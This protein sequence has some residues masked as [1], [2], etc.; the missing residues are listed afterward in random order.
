MS[1][2]TEARDEA[3]EQPPPTTEAPSEKTEK[4]EQAQ[5]A[6]SRSWSSPDTEKEEDSG[7]R[8][9]GS[10]PFLILVALGVAILIKTFVVQ[11]F[12][13]PSESMVPTLEVGDRV[14]VNKILF[15][16]GDIHRFDVVVFENPNS[17]ELPDRS[18]IGGFLHWLGEGIGLSQPENEDF[19]KRVI[20]LP[21]ETVEIRRHTVYVDGRPLDEPYLT[22]AARQANG[23]WG[24]KTVPEGTLFVMGDNRGN[25]ADS[26]FGL[27]F[28]PIDKVV[29]KAFIVIWPP[30]NAGGLS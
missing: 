18:V 12:Y 4:A 9:V 17:A 22:R 5:K 6:G 30:S 3:E 10:T 25:S 13:I 7:R 29:G 16:A 2:I 14:F 24:P 15:D 1:E 20:G 27:G 19:I 8:F 21:G 26:R 23:D 28:V 11:A